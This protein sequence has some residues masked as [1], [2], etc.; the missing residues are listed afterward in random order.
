MAGILINVDDLWNADAYWRSG[1]LPWTIF[2]YPSGL[3]DSQ[4]LP[5]DEEARRYLAELLGHGIRVG[6]WEH[7]DVADA[8]YFACPFEDRD[9]VDLAIMQLE[10]LNR[11]TPGFA[12]QHC[13]YLFDTSG[14]KN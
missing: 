7:P 9:R 6:I 5:L 3:A 12:A 2:A 1:I 11:F 14:K 13:K 4:R 10:R 8:I